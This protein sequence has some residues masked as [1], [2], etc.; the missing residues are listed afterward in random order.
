MVPGVDDR[1]QAVRPLLA[2]AA[3]AACGRGDWSSAVAIAQAAAALDP[4]DPAVVAALARAA[5]GAGANASGTRRRLTVMFCDLVGS[6]EIASALD[7]E[8]TRELLHAYHEAC[9]EIVRRHDGH[10]AHFMGDGV[11]IYFGYP[12]AHEDDGLRAVLTALAVVDAV[13]QLRSR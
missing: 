10:I 2:A 11:L 9:A 3:A 8:D 5:A 4:E 12:R 6:T 13:S 7:P 1:Q